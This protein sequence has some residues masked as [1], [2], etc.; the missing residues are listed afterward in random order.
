MQFLKVSVVVPVYNGGEYL[1]KCV[2]SLVGQSLSTGE[3]EIVFI[4]DGSI[5]GSAAYLDS[6]AATHDHVS[7]IHQANSGWPGQP[8]NLGIDK[9]RGEYVFFCDADDWLARETLANLYSVAVDSRADVVIPKMA[10]LNRRVADHL[11][12][13]TRLGVTLATAPLMDSL[14]PHKL[15]R[16]DFLNEHRIRF[17]EGEHR[18]E[19]HYFMANAYLRAD[20]ISIAADQTYYFHI[21][22]RDRQ[23]ISLRPVK[24][25]EYYRCLAEAVSIVEQN[26]EPGEFRDR[27]FRRWLQVEICGRLSGKAFLKRDP[28]EAALLFEAAHALARQHFGDGVVQLLPPLLQSVGVAVIDGDAEAVRRQAL[29]LAAWVLEAQVVQ[30]AWVAGQLQI[31]GTVSVADNQRDASPEAVIQRFATLFPATIQPKVLRELRSQTVT[32][33]LVN[34]SDGERWPVAV[35]GHGAGLR[36]EFTADIDCE[37][38]ANGQPLRHGR[39]NLQAV[40]REL[41]FAVRQ[42]PEL[43]EERMPPEPLLSNS[44]ET[45]RVAVI[46]KQDRRLVI[47]IGQVP[48]ATRVPAWARRIARRLPVRLRQRLRRTRLYRRAS[49]K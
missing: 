27:I 18:L 38:A 2:D 17:P 9:A 49:S 31:S 32:L 6:V 36:M 48:P 5:N 40:W 22:R 16:R 19:D 42:Y 28:E 30:M 43:V 37:R 23:N 15:F 35:R 25:T 41:G 33:E 10:G 24:W 7:V 20:A 3:Y 34:E 46:V 12:R 1:P 4:D 45:R 13:Q 44:Q 29:A 11:F 39:W 14:T 8:R 21:K 26:T 47:Q